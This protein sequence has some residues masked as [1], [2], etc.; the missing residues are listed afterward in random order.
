MFKNTGRKIIVF[1]KILFTIL[2]IAGLGAS[3]YLGYYFYFVKKIDL[4]E[5][6]YYYL[7]VLGGILL[8]PYIAWGISIFAVGFGELIDNSAA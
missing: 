2:L 8:S 3:L 6:W 1:G 4:I 5:N 7:C